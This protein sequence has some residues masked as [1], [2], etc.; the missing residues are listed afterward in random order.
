MDTVTIHG[1]RNFPTGRSFDIQPVTALN[2]P[3]GSGKSTVMSAIAAAWFMAA[4][5]KLPDFN[6]YPF[7][8]GSY[9]QTAHQEGDH[10]PV[11]SFS[12]TSRHGNT[13]HRTEYVSHQAYPHPARRIIHRADNAV[14]ISID[15]Q[16]GSSHHYRFTHDGRKSPQ[17]A[18]QRY[19]P[20]DDTLPSFQ[21]VILEQ[22][23]T[24]SALPQAIRELIAEVA[25][26]VNTRMP[27]H[28]IL[29]GIAPPPRTLDPDP[30]TPL[31]SPVYPY[32]TMRAYE[33]YEPG[34]WRKIR[35]YLRRMGRNSGLFDDIRIRRLAPDNAAPFQ[36][37]VNTDDNWRNVADAGSTIIR[38]LP[39]MAQ[40][41][42]SLVEDRAPRILLL[43]SLDLV[44]HPSA[45]AAIGDFIRSRG[46][47]AICILENPHDALT[48][49]A[50]NPK[51]PS[52]A[53][54]VLTQR[55]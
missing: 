49:A 13:Y 45:N 17:Y 28:S 23:A 2:G 24:G 29:P 27:P 10:P 21:D 12:I 32:T 11:E 26:S 36:V 1:L 55:E 22:Q 31:H 35:S 20:V 33:N 38:I 54:N 14:E 5:A 16:G 40:L 19:G 3:P 37:E 39:L 48:G 41:V 7:L 6:A 47:N 30:Q 34:T 51:Y 9:E 42:M 50:A 43:H 15:P 25:I 52:L 44:G 4:R 46:N 18:I 8:M 53:V